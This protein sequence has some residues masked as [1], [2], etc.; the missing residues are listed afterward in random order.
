MTI[1][2]EYKA[3]DILTYEGVEER[4]IHVD[5]LCVVTVKMNTTRLCFSQYKPYDVCKA[6]IDGTVTVRSDET[7]DKVV[8]LD[9]IPKKYKLIYL[10]NK[11]LVNDFMIAYG[12]YYETW[13][14][15]GNDFQKTA[16]KYN[17]SVKNYFK[18]VRR[19][20][21][22]G[23]SDFS[24]I[25]KRTPGINKNE[26]P[27]N[28]TKKTGRPSQY[29]VR[30]CI[31]NDG[32]RMQFKEALDEL[33]KHRCVSIVNGY[34]SIIEKHHTSVKIENGVVSL[35]EAE[36]ETQPTYDQFYYYVRKNTTKQ[37]FDT[38]R[39]SAAEVRN[40]KRLLLS[41]ALYGVYGIGDMVE[42]DACEVDVSIVDVNDIEQSV[43]RPILYCMIDVATRMILAISVS[44][45][46]NS[47][48]GVTNLFLN[49]SDDKE[50]YCRRF[51]IEGINKSVW[52]SN[53]IPRRVRFDR[54]AECTSK[55]L[56][57]IFNKLKITR[58][59]VTAAT[60][61]LKGNIEQT[62][63]QLHIAQNN[64]LEHHGLIEK[65]YD[66][67]NHREAVLTIEEYT[68]IVINFVL[69]H[70][71]TA[72]RNF[73]LTK[74]MIQKGVHPIPVEL[75]DY[76]AETVGEPRQI[77]S[78]NITQ[79]RFDLMQEYTAIVNREGIHFTGGHL[80]YN[81]YD[82]KLKEL[83]YDSGN[84]KI[85]FKVRYDPRN[86]NNLYYVREGKLFIASMNMNK[87][88]NNGFENLTYT[89]MVNLD[90][91][92]RQLFA[93]TVNNNGEIRRSRDSANKAIVANAIENHGS[94]YSNTSDIKT[95]RETAK[96]NS[97]FDNSIA[98]RFSISD[99]FNQINS[100]SDDALTTVTQN[101][102][103][104]NFDIDE[105]AVMNPEELEEYERTIM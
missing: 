4:I 29:H 24:L 10:K 79:F 13:R 26:K 22:S 77:S 97:R 37:E 93:E 48:L 85:N 41:D 88:V 18:K 51:G 32:I 54:G 56:E 34:D 67:R 46:N 102:D 31:V 53:I 55:Q 66:S 50:E 5:N 1:L 59:L 7:E 30:K 96:Q 27:Y 57:D 16:K 39:T 3:G 86:V 92:K 78:K 94:N 73:K 84:K 63:H 74:D 20:F 19:Y 70:N 99:T 15:R 87:S 60:G 2:S 103:S 36:K 104:D 75:W 90:R 33:K 100:R 91:K 58:E 52:R 6:L 9:D 21:Q 72:I 69:A 65:R 89:E 83:M 68:K 105:L 14:Q 62:F 81:A 28:Y 17:L 42:I 98:Q 64:V 49:L 95:H 101:D 38:I 76:F 80:Y 25:S 47:V 8:N 12:P 45:E 40:N 82:E 43:S 61:S 23:C 11:E 44:F 71:Q 35:I